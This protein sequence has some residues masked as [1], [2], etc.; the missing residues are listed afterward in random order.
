MQKIFM[1]K[2]SDKEVE[3]VNIFIGSR[4]KIISVTANYVTGSDTARVPGRWLIVAD[5]GKDINLKI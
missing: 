4:G 5:D 2:E 3:K 1:V